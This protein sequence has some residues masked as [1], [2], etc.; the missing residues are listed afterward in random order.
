MLDNL[1]AFYVQQSR[2]SVHGVASGKI[3]ERAMHVRSKILRETLQVTVDGTRIRSEYSGNQGFI[4]CRFVLEIG[5]L[6]AVI[7]A[8]DSV[9][10]EIHQ[11]PRCT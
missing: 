2:R 10:G 6:I 4:M 8:S 3:K 9:A 11:K 5:R 7:V 1:L